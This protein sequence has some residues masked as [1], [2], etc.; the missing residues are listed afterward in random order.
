MIILGEDT[1]AGVPNDR[2]DNVGVGGVAVKICRIRK[3]STH[4]STCVD[5]RQDGERI[6]RGLQNENGSGPKDG[7]Y[8]ATGN[9]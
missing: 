9:A 3:F 4:V 8:S 5:E 1:R 2:L 7:R 6:M